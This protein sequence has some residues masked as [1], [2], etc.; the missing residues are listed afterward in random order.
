MTAVYP[1]LYSDLESRI[2]FIE[3]TLSIFGV[4]MIISALGLT[5]AA[6]WRQ[7]SRRR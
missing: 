7:G 1:S 6:L 5:L 3:R 2:T 4:L